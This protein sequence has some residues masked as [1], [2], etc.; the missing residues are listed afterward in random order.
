[1]GHIGGDEALEA[2]GIVPVRR[3]RIGRLPFLPGRTES[4]ATDDLRP[5]HETSRVSEGLSQVKS[6]AICKNRAS[7]SVRIEQAQ[8]GQWTRISVPVLQSVRLDLVR[9][10]RLLADAVDR[11]GDPVALALRRDLDLPALAVEHE[12]HGEDR[13]E[14]V[15]LGAAR[16][17]DVGFP[18]ADVRVEKSRMLLTVVAGIPGRCP[19]P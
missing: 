2:L 17:G 13:L 12:R 7:A 18:R 10:H 19:G 8:S 5:N 14:R 16:R 6:S 15:A 3:G 4:P 11:E 1:M 9:E